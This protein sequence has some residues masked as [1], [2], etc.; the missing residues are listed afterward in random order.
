[1]QRFRYLGQRYRQR[2]KS[3][4]SVVFLCS[5]E[6]IVRWAGIPQKS[7]RYMAGFQRAEIKGHAEEI[8]HF[9]E[10]EANASPTSIVVA[11]KPDRVRIKPLPYQAHEDVKGLTPVPELVLVEV[12]YSD[13][14]ESAT[15]DELAAR[16]SALIR[17]DVGA[18][19]NTDTPL[20]VLDEELDNNTNNGT[21][22]IDDEDTELEIE[23]SHLA[24]FL[25][26]LESPEALQKAKD[27]DEPRLRELLLDLLK[28]ATIVD[29]QHR[30]RGASRV[31][32]NIPFSV[33]GLLDANWPEQVF[34][35][36]VINQKA[37]P[38]VAEFLSAI[39]SSSLTSQQIADLQVRLKQ[40]KVPLDNTRIMDLVHGSDKSPFRGMINFQIKGGTGRMK[41]SG[42]LSLA[43]RFRMLRT[44][45][46]E[47][48]FKD[49]FR[50]VF[51]PGCE[52]DAY[53]DKREAWNNGVWFDYF[54]AFWTEVRASFATD[55]Y[56]YLWEAGSGT[57][58]LKIV[59]LQ[60]LQNL[61]LAWLSSRAEPLQAP[62]DLRK[63]AKH[64]LRHLKVKFFDKDWKL[65]SL[66]S[67]TGR[68]Y[69]RQ[70]I[71]HAV[72]SSNYKYEDP[73]FKGVTS[74]D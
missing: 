20:D 3:M 50:E 29:G 28:P 12:D 10:D 25:E 58:L 61:F 33:V 59:T 32:E 44:H 15:T 51:A 63:A 48:K 14:L 11:F 42:M 8:E 41:Y 2:P 23:S 38:I 40:A 65:P 43:R 52:G 24:D 36:V 68:K 55:D 7:A 31:E 49:F 5:A 21:R 64:Y 54:A 72:Q 69:L 27:E 39:I 4:E 37:R 73:L 34:Q 17:R 16:V 56:P 26:L 1:M 70:A 74:S 62:A 35:F 9:F 22:D 67:S 57:N 60:E 53:R 47:I 13:D 46:S 71:N 30:A 18:S 45:E 19:I 6:D 66:Q